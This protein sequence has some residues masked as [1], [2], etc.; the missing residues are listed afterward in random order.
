MNVQIK[1]TKTQL[2]ELLVQKVP[3]FAEACHFCGVVSNR[4]IVGVHWIEVD[5]DLAYLVT[6]DPKNKLALDSPRP[7]IPPGQTVQVEADFA[8]PAT[9]DH[10]G[11]M[12]CA[13]VVCSRCGFV[14]FLSLN[15]LGIL[16]TKK[17]PSFKLIHGGGESPDAV[18]DPEEPSVT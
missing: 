10:P 16:S 4:D 8:G 14:A 13:V 9:N 2:I 6:A 5:D 3:T 18:T 11:H 12:A 15:Q 1:L 17:K 7:K